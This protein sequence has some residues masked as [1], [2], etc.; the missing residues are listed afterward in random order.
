MRKLE[1]KQQQ[2]A[3]L[4]R[5]I[6]LAAEQ[7]ATVERRLIEITGVLAGVLD[8]SVRPLDFEALKIPLVL[9]SLD[10]GGDAEPEPAPQ[11]E[12]YA[13]HTPGAISRAFGGAN[14]YVS[15][16]AAA[17]K[18]FE[19]AQR[20]HAEREIAR[21]QRVVAKRAAH[22]ERITK[23]RQRIEAQ[24]AEIDTFREKVLN[25]DRFAVSEYYQRLIDDITMP[26]GFPTARRAAYVPESTELVIE[27]DVPGL[28]IVPLEKEFQFVKTRKTIEVR[29]KRPIEEI[30]ST[31]QDIICQ[32][33]LQ[34]VH[35]AFAADLNEL[36]DTVVV[37]GMIDM[38]DP[39]I[40]QP[41][42]PCRIT[43]RATRAQYDK[44]NL[45]QVK[46]VECVRRF[47]GAEVTD[48]PEALASVEPYLSFDMA[49]P[50]LVDP[51]DI[52]S[53]L[54]RRPNL[55]DMEHKEFEHF[56]QN[57]FDRMGFDTKQF[58]AS[59][60]GGIDC[61]A[62]DPTPIRGGKYVI[63]VKHYKDTVQPS[64]VRDLFGVVHAEGATKGILITTSG[65]GPSSYEFANGKP[66]QLYD[67]TR[68]LW[69]CHQQGIEARIVMPPK[70]KKKAK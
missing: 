66:L 12:D 14:R 52:L 51:V 23:Q 50:R 26:T 49:D 30:R 43:L 8:R 36:V 37:N 45:H 3:E 28:D 11:W 61:I 56:I 69:L 48:H 46:A 54:D 53:K 59:G 64:A 33:A 32:I 63:Q 2:E 70:T 10:L 20:D 67:G 13:P 5:Q 44:V 57:L 35:A 25:G 31:Y 60:D 42:R 34:A 15:R 7:T 38:I 68:L 40:G 27:W 16:R 6:E 4:Q 65:F 21:Q 24:H 17:D 47:F 29:K 22:A 1:V 18:R 39:A 58:Q 19:R 41:V 55:M 62:Y 9:P